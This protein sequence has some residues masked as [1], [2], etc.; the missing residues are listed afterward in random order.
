MRSTDLRNANAIAVLDV[1]HYVAHAEQEHLLNQIRAALGD[2]GLI[3]TRVG[4]AGSGLRFV[5]SQIVDFCIGLAREHRL[6]RLW[7]LPL[8]SWISALESRGFVVQAVP[9]SAGTVFANVML[10]SRVA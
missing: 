10:I 7:C 3:V 9:M 5:Q 1:L 6:E 8:A 4:D 2:G